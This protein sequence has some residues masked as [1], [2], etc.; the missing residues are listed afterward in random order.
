MAKDDREAEPVSATTDGI[1]KTPGVCGGNAC[2]RGR[3]IP[4]WVLVEARRLGMTEARLLEAHPTLSSEDL[5]AAWDYAAANASEIERNIWENQAAMDEAGGDR[6]LALIIRGWQLGLSDDAIADAFSPPLTP[7]QLDAARRDYLARK[8]V[9]DG[10][11]AG[12]L[13]KELRE[14]LSTDAAA[15][16]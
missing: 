11:L 3:R 7:A 1:T 4:V 8:D 12:L 6:R 15:V 9:L 14:G 5:G 10:A 16:C 13:P 2:I